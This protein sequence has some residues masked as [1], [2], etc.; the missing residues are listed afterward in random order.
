MSL[1]LWLAMVACA[2][3]ISAPSTD[4]CDQRFADDRVLRS[5]CRRV[6]SH[7]FVSPRGPLCALK[8]DAK[9][10]VTVATLNVGLL[11]SVAR[12]DDRRAL[13]RDRFGEAMRA[14]GV[15]VLLIQELFERKDRRMFEGVARDAGYEIVHETSRSGLA[16]VF[17]A[18][19]F[20][21]IRATSTRLPGDVTALGGFT[22]RV[23]WLEVIDRRSGETYVFGNTHA[24][25]I[26]RPYW[27][28]MRSAQ[29]TRMSEALQVAL[30]DC[31]NRAKRECMLVLGGDFN[32]SNSHDWDGRTPWGALGPRDRRRR[33][34]LLRWIQWDE[35]LYEV[36]SRTATEALAVST[37]EFMT[38]HARNKVLMTSKGAAEEPNRRVDLL[39]LVRGAL[40]N[41]RLVFDD[42][43]GDLSFSDH[44]GLAASVSAEGDCD[45]RLAGEPPGQRAERTEE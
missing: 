29:I 34:R 11:P 26:L 16:I 6:M 14:E 18:S 17:K 12:L 28:N 37:A 1:L 22:R 13:F 9:D 44:F 36:L 5:M 4:G 43:H 2:E 7:R 21:V 45:G 19:R 38:E 15:D 25:P 27:G 31:G 10:A 35:F 23:M 32:L 8:V 3:R 20:E 30:A 41:S 33:Q 42:A 39:F 24:S 40:G